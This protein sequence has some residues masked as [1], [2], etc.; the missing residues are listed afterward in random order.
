MRRTLLTLSLFLVAC[1]PSRGG[2]DDDDTG[3]IDARGGSPDANN[4]GPDGG[5]GGPDAA[6]NGGTT[7]VFAHTASTLFRVDPITYAIT[8]VGDFAWPAGNDS[9][10]DIAIDENGLMIGTSFNRVYRVDPDTAA[11]TML[12][13]NL[14]GMFNGLSFVPGM[15][16]FG[17][18]GPDVLVGTR[19]ADGKVFEVNPMTGATTEIGDMGEGFSSSGDIV[20][21][22]GFGM[23]ATVPTGTF[24]PDKLV[25]LA[26]TTFAATPIGASTGFD[27]LWGVGFWA[28]RVFGFS[29]GGNLTIIDSATGVGTSVATGG[30]AWWGAAVTTAAPLIP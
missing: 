5:N 12:S 30:E 22:T 3:G 18:D 6:D 11:C 10:T 23:V 27:D 26:P 14:Q 16:A 15:L 19:A 2:D 17:V 25:R 4:G 20:A 28:G 13:N 29:E 24:G 1:G 9:M 8:R 21:V 7:A